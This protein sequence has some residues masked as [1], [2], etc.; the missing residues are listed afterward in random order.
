MVPFHQVLDAPDTVRILLSGELD[1]SVREELHD[2][3]H[4]AARSAGATEVDLHHV[5]FLDCSVIGELVRAYLDARRHGQILVV[6]R[7]QGFVREVLELTNVLTLLTS[8]PAAL[9]RDA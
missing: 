8:R 6:T 3:L 5:T 1:I 2:V 9:V 7:P 4:D